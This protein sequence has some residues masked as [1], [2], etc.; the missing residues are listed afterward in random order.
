MGSYTHSPQPRMAYR[1]ATRSECLWWQQCRAQCGGDSAAFP[2]CVTV[3]PLHSRSSVVCPKEANAL[4]CWCRVRVDICMCLSMV[5]YLSD[6][7][8]ESGGTWCVPGS[9]RSALN[10]RGPADGITVTAPIPGELQC[11]GPA[12]SLFIQD[13][14]MWHSSACWSPHPRTALVCRFAPW[15]LSVGEFGQVCSLASR[16]SSCQ[17][18][19]VMRNVANARVVYAGPNW[20]PTTDARAAER[21]LLR[22]AIAC[23]APLP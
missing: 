22:A 16:A 9:H 13:T 1:L 10:P 17:H 7:G 8:P 5:W 23:P 3:H 6:T 15:W 19:C 14:R 11:E 2:G 12:G 4:S 21:F 20:W 18:V